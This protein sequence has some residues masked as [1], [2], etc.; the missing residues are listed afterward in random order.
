MKR[1]RDLS[2]DEFKAEC[3][4]E[5]KCNGS[6][7]GISLKVT[8]YVKERYWQEHAKEGIERLKMRLWGEICFECGRLEE[9]EQQ[10]KYGRME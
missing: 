4:E 10:Y 1:L 9:R 7:V 8:Q 3:I 2:P 6:Q 5:L